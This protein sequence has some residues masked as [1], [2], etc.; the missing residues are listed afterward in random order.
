[1]NNFYMTTSSPSSTSR[2]VTLCKLNLVVDPPW[3]GTLVQYMLLYF[4]W[5]FRC[6][7]VNLDMTDVNVLLY[8]RIMHKF[9][10]LFPHFS[11]MKSTVASESIRGV[12]TSSTVGTIFN[13]AISTSTA[14]W[15]TVHPKLFISLL[16]SSQHGYIVICVG[17]SWLGPCRLTQ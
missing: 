11:T 1:M 2:V 9:F 4:S 7:C 13:C 14:L 17:C 3:C 12:T 10:I 8:D 15:V 16:S 6:I 5:R